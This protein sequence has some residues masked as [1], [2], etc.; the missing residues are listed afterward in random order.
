MPQPSVQLAPAFDAEGAIDKLHVVAGRLV[1][2][3]YALRQ[4]LD[5]AP[6]P[7]ADPDRDP[8]SISRIAILDHALSAAEVAATSARVAL[9]AC[10]PRQSAVMRIQIEAGGAEALLILFNR[11][12]NRAPWGRPVGLLGELAR[13]AQDAAWQV[14]AG[15]ETIAQRLATC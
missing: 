14:R 2:H 6:M 8:G 15:L 12:L 3:L 4:E 7:D 9:S 10:A 13:S 1:A 11:E 5:R